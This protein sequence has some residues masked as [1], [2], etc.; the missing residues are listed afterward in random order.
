MEKRGIYSTNLDKIQVIDNF[1]P[2]AVF[3]KLSASILSPDMPWFFQP[4]VAVFENQLKVDAESQNILDFNV[5]F[6]HVMYAN[7][8]PN[9]VYFEAIIPLL[10]A[11]NFPGIFRANANLT[12]NSGRRI[13]HGMHRDI[14]FEGKTC[15]F[16]LNTTNG[17]TAFEHGKSVDCKENRL[18]IFDSEIA[19]SGVTPTNEKR[20]VVI[21]LNLFNPKVITQKPP[22]SSIGL[23]D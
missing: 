18:L 10:E 20:K 1:L 5:F 6:S 22:I 11:L 17:P 4:N 13:R 12:L 9:S 14:D 3:K 21:N 2:G 16:Y 8:R 19:H 7:G 23:F 15:I